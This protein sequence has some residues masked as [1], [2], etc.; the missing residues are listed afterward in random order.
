[1]P[2]VIPNRRR[3]MTLV[4]LLVVISILTILAVTVIPNIGNTSDRRKVR[5]AARNLS[6]FIAG[7][8]SR[9]LGSH[10]GGGVWFDPLPNKIDSGPLSI[11][12]AIDLADANVPQPY[13][14][15][16]GTSAIS[17]LNVL[18]GNQQAVAT[19]T[20]ACGPLASGTNLIQLAGSASYFL[21]T[22][23]YNAASPVTF[24]TGT[25]SL[26]TG[27]LNQ[28]DANTAWPKVPTSLGLSYRIIGAPTRSPANSLTLSDGVAIDLH[29]STVGVTQFPNVSAPSSLNTGTAPF[30]ILYDS[31]GKPQYLACNG[32]RMPL[33]DPLFLLVAPIA[34]IQT[35]GTLAPA[36]GYWVAIDPRGGIPKVAEV[37]P[38]GG[39][40]VAQQSFIRSGA[41]QYG[42]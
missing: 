16:T 21:L 19:F 1:M 18:S 15:N 36:D 3:G 11:A 9:A 32:S 10:S 25:I 29:H 37:D 4:E 22:A 35:S 24:T 2:T 12:I 23:P 34:S 38:S 41:V 30:Q 7:G 17:A 8:Q 42:R 33:N 40:I 5:E 26:Q 14:G 28:T 31:T 13:C 27:A 20:E 39:T 6:S